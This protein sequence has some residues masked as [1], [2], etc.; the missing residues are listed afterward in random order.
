VLSK[1]SVHSGKYSVH[2]GTHSVHGAHELMHNAAYTRGFKH[3]NFPY[4]LP[5]LCDDSAFAY[6]GLFSLALQRYS[7]TALHTP[8]MTQVPK[9]VYWN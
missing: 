2:R 5:V 4:V 3:M 8:I 1:H 7:V 6:I 9:D